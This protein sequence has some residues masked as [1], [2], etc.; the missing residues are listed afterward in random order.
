MNTY[1]GHNQFQSWPGS[2]QLPPVPEEQDREV[3]STY[4]QTSAPISLSQWPLGPGPVKPPTLFLPEVPKTPELS[5]G[6]DAVL[7]KQEA[8]ASVSARKKTRSR[9]A[10]TITSI[11]AVLGIIVVATLVNTK[12]IADVTLT[13]V[14]AKNATQYIGGGGIVFPRQKLDLS[15][16]VAERV[17]DVLVKAG[18]TVQPNQA[19]I[20][21]DP[22]Q[23]D[24]QVK[25]AAD[26]VAAAQAYLNS[27][28]VSG[29]AINIAQAQQQYDLAKNKYNALVAQTSFPLLHNGS[30]VSP[31]RGVITSVNINPGEVF[32]ADTVLLTIM[33]ESVVIVHAKVPLANIDQV[34]HG[35]QAE[36]TPSSLPGRI[37]HGT[38]TSIIPQVDAQ[39]DTFE[40]WVSIANPQQM[41][42]PG[43]S[44]FV[45]VPLPRRA[46]A[47]PRLAVLNPTHGPVVFVVQGPRAYLRPVQI[48]GRIDDMILID[49]GL[50]S[51][52][53]VVLV[54]QD[55][56]HDGQEVRVRMV[57]G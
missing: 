21:L 24:A 56:L 52:D 46:F 23:L 27:V 44:A 5:V 37:F 48:A 26:N 18:D 43:M 13:Q 34:A 57:E 14:S 10:W 40:I 7:Q 16:P 36:V 3:G 33:D 25:Q 42:L 28:S 35:A 12:A 6:L 41:L 31:M 30:L 39:T 20:R 1:E 8:P 51:G 22:T 53:N 54:G 49:K 55:R 17:V 38:V 32:A 47:V 11:L 4:S 50:S 9:V 29:N 15:Y 19:L 2:P 45:R